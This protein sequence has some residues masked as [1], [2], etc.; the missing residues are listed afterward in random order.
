[1]VTAGDIQSVLLGAGGFI[2]TTMA[3]VGFYRLCISGAQKIGQIPVALISGAEELSRL[4][5]AV[6][7]DQ[8]MVCLVTE[9]SGVLKALRDDNA[10]ILQQFE[11]FHREFRIMSRK[12]EGIPND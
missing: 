5:E 7:R 6:E 8:S 4:R 2:G 9:Q 12:Y 1:M 3:G 11:D 10:K